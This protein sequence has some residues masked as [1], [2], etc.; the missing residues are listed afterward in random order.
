MLPPA[1]LDLDFYLFKENCNYKLFI[2][3]RVVQVE[4]GVGLMRTEA[5]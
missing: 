5:I 4:R 3:D 2:S 1:K